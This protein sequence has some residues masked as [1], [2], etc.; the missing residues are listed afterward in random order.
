MLSRKERIDSA[1]KLGAIAGEL[2]VFV[3]LIADEAL[4]SLTDINFPIQEIQAELEAWR[5]EYVERVVS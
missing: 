1:R 2:G 4:E 5:T 3:H